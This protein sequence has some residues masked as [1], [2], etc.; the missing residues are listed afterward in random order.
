MKAW[1][2]VS[3]KELAEKSYEFPGILHLDLTNHCEKKCRMCFMNGRYEK[4]LFPLGYMSFSLYKSIVDECVMEYGDQ[5]T[6]YLYKDGESLLHPNLGYFINYAKQLGIRTCL[7]T[8]GLKLFEKRKEVIQ[9][10]ELVISTE[11]DSAMESLTKFLE[12]KG[13]KDKPFTEIKLFKEDTWYE[14]VDLP[15]VDNVF[16]SMHYKETRE[17]TTMNAAC[18]H[19]FFN[20]AITWDGYLTVCCSDWRREGVVGDVKEDNIKTLWRVMRHV[21]N[22][23]QNKIFLPPCDKCQKVEHLQHKRIELT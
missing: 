7:A 2:E 9:L 12:Y 23:Q 5:M 1:T 22:L 16:T 10:D 11:D 19:L 8:N 21:K 3:Q 4:S 13:S 17:D 6:L 18:F 14:N 15:K 20:P